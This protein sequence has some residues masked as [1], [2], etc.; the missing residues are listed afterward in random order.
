MA[1]W[2]QRHASAADS[3]RWSDSGAAGTA[4]WPPSLLQQVAGG[5]TTACSGGCRL[6]QDGRQPSPRWD[7]CTACTV[8]EITSGWFE[9]ACANNKSHVSLLLS[10]LMNDHAKTCNIVVDSS[11]HSIK[12]TSLDNILLITHLIT[13][14]NY[15]EAGCWWMASLQWATDDTDKNWFDR[16]RHFKSYDKRC[17]NERKITLICPKISKI[18]LIKKFT[19]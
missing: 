10:R 6:W 14:Y 3:L 4:E 9:T 7:R 8:G 5:Q 2:Q 16:H 17:K 13:F 12:N 1:G 11:A 19:T 18:T 15:V